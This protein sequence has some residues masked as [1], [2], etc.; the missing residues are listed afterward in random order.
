MKLLSI[1]A[2]VALALLTSEASARSI[3]SSPAERAA[4]AQLNLA[5]LARNA[6]EEQ[7]RMALALY[8]EKMRR[9]IAQ[10]GGRP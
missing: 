1:V 5:V 7:Y 6:A 4:T 8:Q 10:Y 3:P 2:A 9:Y